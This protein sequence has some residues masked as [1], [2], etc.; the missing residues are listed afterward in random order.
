MRRAALK[1]ALVLPAALVLLGPA[2]LATAATLEVR[3]PQDGGF[4][5]QAMSVKEARFTRTLRQQFDFSCGSA[6]V[7]T[8]LRFHPFL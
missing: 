3:G 2:S 1:A 5:A 4:A 8:L 7:A 6:A